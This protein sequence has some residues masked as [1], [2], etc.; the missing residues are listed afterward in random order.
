M[1][2][3]S[4]YATAVNQTQE[5]V[6]AYASSPYE[7][8]PVAANAPWVV[9]GSFTVPIAIAARL[10]VQGFNS[11]SAVLS[12]ALFG[13]ALVANSAVTVA[14]TNEGTVVSQ[15]MSLVPGV[16]YQIAVQYLGASGI[17]CV[18]TV[19]LGSL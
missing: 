8:V 17:A 13:P 5:V 19:S 6:C 9:M 18:R 10:V 11:G 15:E 4:G 2:T 16:T 1:S 7:P 12:V 3:L 14:N